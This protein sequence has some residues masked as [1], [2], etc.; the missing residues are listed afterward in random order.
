MILSKEIHCDSEKILAVGGYSP[1]NFP[2]GNV[3]AEWLDVTENVWTSLPDYPFG[4]S[5]IYFHV[6]N[7][8]THFETLILSRRG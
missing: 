6:D 3:K 7:P 1:G 5:F 4:M 8:E 2:A